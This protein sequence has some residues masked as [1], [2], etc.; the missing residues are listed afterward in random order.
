LDTVQIYILKKKNN[1]SILYNILISTHENGKIY[2]YYYNLNNCNE[3]PEYICTEAEI[4]NNVFQRKNFQEENITLDNKNISVKQI[5]SHFNQISEQDEKIL[6]FI[7][8]QTTALL[9]GVMILVF[10]NAMIRIRRKRKLLEEKLKN[11]S[12]LLF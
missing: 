9:L 6:M 8:I 4:N 5:G 11:P 10:F 7:I 1:T 3:D 12:S 2:S